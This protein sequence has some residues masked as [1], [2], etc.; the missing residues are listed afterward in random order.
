MRVIIRILAETMA[1]TFKQRLRN[2][3][4]LYAT[5]LRRAVLQNVYGM[6]IGENTRISSTAKLDKTNPKGVHIG[7]HTIVTFQSAILTHD[8]VNRRHVN[9]YVGDY[10]FIGAHSVIMPGVRIGNH[11]VVGAGSIVTRDVP[12][13]S[14]VVGNPARVVRS[15]ITTIEFGIMD[16]PQIP[17]AGADPMP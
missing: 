14:I 17:M 13:N 1:L 6:T 7:S 2:K 15:G 3:L 9:T 16:V 5:I 8:F 4:Y 10:C 12:D 11:C